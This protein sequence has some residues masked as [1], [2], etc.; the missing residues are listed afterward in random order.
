MAALALTAICTAAAAEPALFVT[1]SVLSVPA[2]RIATYTGHT[3]YL[4]QEQLE[5]M[6]SQRDTTQALGTNIWQED[7][8]FSSS[9]D[10]G[11]PTFYYHKAD[12]VFLKDLFTALGVDEAGMRAIGKVTLMASDKYVTAFDRFSDLERYYFANKEMKPEDGVPVE[13]MLAFFSANQ[14]G[15]PQGL[16]EAEQPAVPGGME[17]T[18]MF[19]QTEAEDHNNCNYAKY[20]KCV[21]LGGV[22]ALAASMLGGQKDVT[23]YYTT[24]DLMMRGMVERSYTVNGTD[25]RAQGLDLKAFADALTEGRP[26]TLAFTTRQNGLEKQST[27]R[28]RSDELEEGAYLLAWYSQKGAEP[29]ANETEL[30]LYGENLSM[31]NLVSITLTPTEGNP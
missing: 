11:Q 29:V 22:Q 30:R 2:D 23:T 25:Y 16:E 18:F 20:T 9:E 5:Q 1:G 21:D 10:H 12:G 28:L 19:G 13:A 3:F 8:Y 7:V 14:A 15:T 17:P 24:A 4:T 6:L 31:A 27:K 26:Y